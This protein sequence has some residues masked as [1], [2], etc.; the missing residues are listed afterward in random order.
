MCSFVTFDSWCRVMQQ[1]LVLLFHKIVPRKTVQ[2]LRF[3]IIILCLNQLQLLTWKLIQNLKKINYNLI[4]FSALKASEQSMF[5][6]LQSKI[7]KMI[8][9]YRF[10]SSNLQSVLPGSVVRVEI[11]E[12]FSDLGLGG[13]SFQT[14]E[15]QIGFIFLLHKHLLKSCVIIVHWIHSC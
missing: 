10:Q 14:R 13:V 1:P 8:H 6:C 11:L 12:N 7:K 4:F 5:N 2:I 9:I 3:L 15:Q